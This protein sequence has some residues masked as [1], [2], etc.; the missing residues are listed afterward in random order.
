[1]LCHSSLSLAHFPFNY[2]IPP[3]PFFFDVSQV[4]H[5]D[6]CTCSPYLLPPPSLARIIIPICKSLFCS[7]VIFCRTFLNIL[8]KILSQNI[9]S[10]P[11]FLEHLL[12]PKII[13]LSVH[14]NVSSRRRKVYFHCY[15]S[16]T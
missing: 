12:P 16:V 11:T 15:I 5:L 10:C 8:Y 14:Q 9:I 13:D 6:L 1:M 4:Y 3:P 7:N 2:T